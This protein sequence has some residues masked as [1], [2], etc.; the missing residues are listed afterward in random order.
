MDLVRTATTYHEPTCALAGA[1]AKK[2]N[3]ARAKTLPEVLAAT[4]GLPGL[5][6]PCRVCITSA[7]GIKF[8]EFQQAKQ[9]AGR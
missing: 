1:N 4:H 8:R 2:W 3:W 9:G 7:H 6:Q 5:A